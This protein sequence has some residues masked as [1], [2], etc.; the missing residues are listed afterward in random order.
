MPFIAA[1]VA[2]PSHPHSFPLSLSCSTFLMHERNKACPWHWLYLPLMSFDLDWSLGLLFISN[3][4]LLKRP[5]Q[6]SWS[7]FHIQN[8]SDCF[9]MMRYRL[10]NLVWQGHFMRHIVPGF[11]III[12]DKCCHLN[13]RL[14]LSSFW[15]CILPLYFNK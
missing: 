14:S 7:I 11:T 4:N 2:P 5:D 10:K 9:F 15:R 6:K 13:E 3:I 12:N 1:P 8:V